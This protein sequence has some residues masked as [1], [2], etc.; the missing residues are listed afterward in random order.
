MKTLLQIHA[1]L[2]SDNGESSHLSDRL[3]AQWLVQNPDGEVIRHDLAIDPIPHLDAEIF[4]AWRTPVAERSLTQQRHA[5]RSEQLIAELQA[6]QTVVIAAPMYNFG[7]PSTLKAWIDQVTRAG[8]SFRYGANGPEGL[9]TGKRAVV[10]TTRGGK[11]EGT[12]ADGV[13]P[14]LKQVLGFIGIQD[15]EIVYAEGLAMEALRELSLNHA[16]T[17][18]DQWT[19]TRLAA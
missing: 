13:V 11:H 17:Q 3:A 14:Y 18:I 1:S 8:L 5:A 7:I 6:A 16:Q 15:V 9:I 19:T 2:S 10:I 12:A 4:S